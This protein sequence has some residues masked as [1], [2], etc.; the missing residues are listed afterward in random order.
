MNF[1]DFFQVGRIHILLERDT[2]HYTIEA[3]NLPEDWKLKFHFLGRRMR[4]RDAFQYALNSLLRR[5][6]MI[7]NTDCYVAKGF[8]RVNKSILNNKTFYLFLGS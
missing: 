3:Q 7:M 6:V 8:E 4:Y 2:D 1:H 5:N